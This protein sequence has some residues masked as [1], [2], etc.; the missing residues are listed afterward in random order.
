MR[1][2]SENATRK[3]IKTRERVRKHRMRQN[4]WKDRQN[5]VRDRLQNTNCSSNDDTIPVTVSQENKEKSFVDELRGW[6]KQHNISVIAINHLLKILICFGFTWLPSDYRSFLQTP[7]N[8]EISMLADGKFWY[9]GI[10]KT[11]RHVFS[12][13]TRDI[14][15]SLKFNVDGLPLFNSSK[16]QFWPLLASIHGK[17]YLDFYYLPIR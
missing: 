9:N 17:N 16:L 13:L 1:K 10:G 8:V 15:I 7:R 2:C 14:C 4:L 3:T 12:T 5:L 11:L 6:S